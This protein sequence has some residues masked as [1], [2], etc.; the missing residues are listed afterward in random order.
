[1]AR[2]EYRCR[3][4]GATFEQTRPMA[5]AN[6]PTTCPAGHTDT[7]K[8]FSAI[9]VGGRAGGPAPAAGGGCCGGACCS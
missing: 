5:E 1:M 4:C 8:L 7:V 3:S 2:Y 9:S 6:S